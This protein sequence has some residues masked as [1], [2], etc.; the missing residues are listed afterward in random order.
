MFKLFFLPVFIF[1]ASCSYQSDICNQKIVIGNFIEQKVNLEVSCSE[2][3]RSKGLMNRK[4]LAE[5][6]GMIFV[7]PSEDY[8]SFWMKNTLIPL[9]IAFV[10]KDMKIVDIREMQPHNLE[11]IVS[12]KK[13]IIAI[14][15]NT[16]WFSKNSI[17]V[18]DT[19]KI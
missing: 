10:D 4:F 9:S 19:F 13:A 16:K 14:E 3:Q 17:K 11:P 2:S 15:M 1:I 7:F 6:D 8:L 5:N 12:T 18:G